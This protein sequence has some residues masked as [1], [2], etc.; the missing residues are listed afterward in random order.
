[1]V[2]SIMATALCFFVSTASAQAVRKPFAALNDCWTA[3]NGAPIRGANAQLNQDFNLIQVQRTGDVGRNS[4]IMTEGKD[5]FVVLNAEGAQ[6]L[7]PT[8][9][10][11]ANAT[12]NGFNN[13]Q[14]SIRPPGETQKM[15][16]AYFTFKR[17]PRSDTLGW[18][19]PASGGTKKDDF[20]AKY[21]ND[22]VRALNFTDTL[23]AL[24]RIFKEKAKAEQA[25]LERT[26]SR[27]QVWNKLDRYL[28]DGRIVR[29]TNDDL[30][31]RLE[32]ALS[33]VDACSDV[34][35]ETIKQAGLQ[36]K[37]TLR[38]QKEFLETL[39][40]TSLTA[41]KNLGRTKRSTR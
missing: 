20:Y 14:M 25:D 21:E 4:P 30:R 36:H 11:D 2:K 18:Y 16:V 35:D 28:P 37:D 41:P 27:L 15:Q 33:L 10:S 3:L 1:M 40:N 31:R 8:S 17:D 9:S 22:P 24:R 13:Y 7:V 12:S 38:Q 19:G 34:G 5:N 29:Q 6:L 32:S 23:E 39:T 26:K